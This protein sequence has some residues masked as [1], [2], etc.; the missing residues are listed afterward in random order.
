M[1]DTQADNNE[2]DA[3]KEDIA[4]LREDVAR[5]ASAVL[6]AA[7]EKIDDAKAEVNRKGQDATDELTGRVSEGIDRGKQFLDDLDAQVSRHPVGSTLI[8]FGVGLLI[9]K[10]LG[11][12]DRH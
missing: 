2:V 8:A 12:G 9:A 11:S 4:K 7:S 1:M 5:L 6:D 10:I 3:L